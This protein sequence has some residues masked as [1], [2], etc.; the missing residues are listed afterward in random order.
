MTEDMSHYRDDTPWGPFISKHYVGLTVSRGDIIAAAVVFGLTH[1]F[2]LTAAYLG[3][4][5]TKACR[6]PWRCAYIWMIWL[7]MAACLAL[8]MECFFFLLRFMGP[9]FYFYMSICR[10]FSFCYDS[11]PCSAEILTN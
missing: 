6:K 2:A 5:Q 10:S 3:Y 1:I 9:S 4:H 11:E 8:S 7:E